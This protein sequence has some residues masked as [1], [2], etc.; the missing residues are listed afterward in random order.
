MA[1]A[2]VTLPKGYQLDSQPQLPPGYKLDSQ[3][4]GP[5]QEQPAKPLT[6]IDQAHQVL[7][8]A[9]DNLAQTG[10]GM[11]NAVA[12][13]IDTV[14]G[15]GTAQ[16]ALRLKAEEAFKKGDYL[17]GLQHV[18]N[19]AIPVVGPSIDQLGEEANSG[20]PGAIAHAVGGSLA[21]GGQLAGPAA[22]ARTV[23]AAIPGAPPPQ[24]LP[25]TSAVAERMY[26]Q[27][28]NPRVTT[29]A[30]EVR[31]MVQTG[32]ENKIPVSEAGQAKLG[33]L[34]SDLNQKIQAH[35]AP[36][37][38]R[39]VKVDPHAVAGRLVDVEDRIRNQVN[40]EHDIADVNKSGQEFLRSRG[41]A[42]GQPAGAPQPTGVLD[43]QGKPV[44]GP[45]KPAVPATKA[46]AIPADE[47]QAIKVGTY[48][49]LAGKFGEAATDAQ[50]EAQKALARGI[51][52]ELNAQIPELKDL[53]AKEGSL[54][55]LQGPL[56]NAVNKS[57]NRKVLDKSVPVAMTSAAG[58]VVAG[59]PG[60][61]AGAGLG[62]LRQVLSNPEVRSR[63]AI[64]INQAKRSNPGKW[65]NPDLAASTARVS[66]FAAALGKNDQER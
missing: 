64:A 46:Q 20:R 5:T 62:I 66:S 30:G 11:V 21:L 48:R 55:D 1:D 31:A 60:A 29:P 51:K 6:W 18:V 35:V 41:Q 38:A 24:V 50:V 58:G 13:P 26:Q 9:W 17:G 33:N 47:A 19:Y 10:Q 57:V 16:D 59:G 36:A 56:E 3:A 44:M 40:P 32:L 34:L 37:A 54:F 61:A 39:G 25:D 23:P 52:E 2:A 42:P 65:G 15:I 27:A 4:A 43:A 14:K 63:L 12:H 22:L 28:L 8:G 45:G 49:K 53:N 7:K